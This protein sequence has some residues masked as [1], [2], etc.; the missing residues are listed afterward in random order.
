MTMIPHNKAL[1]R[2]R[3]RRELLPLAIRPRRSTTF[4]GFHS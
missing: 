4:M 3:I 1:Q 2:M